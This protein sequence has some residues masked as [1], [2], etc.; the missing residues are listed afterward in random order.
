[1]VADERAFMAVSLDV[2]GIPALQ[3]LKCL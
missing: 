2:D 1:L 3:R